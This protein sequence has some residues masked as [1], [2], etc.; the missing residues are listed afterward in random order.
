MRAHLFALACAAT[1]CLEHPILADDPPS[2][3][4]Q[5]EPVGPPAAGRVAIVLA[6][7]LG[8]GPDDFSKEVVAA[9][10]ADGHSV[11]ATTVPSVD[12]VA[13]RAAALGPQI[14]KM[15]AEAGVT[16]VHVIAHSMGGL[17]A[18][19][20]IATL[21][22]A[23]RIA[24]LT[25]ISTPH[26]GTALADAA[27]GLSGAAAQNDA[28]Q[29]FAELSPAADPAA[30]DRALRDLQT[31]AAP[32][33]NAANPDAAGVVYLSFAGFSTPE[34]IANANAP[35]ACGA[36]AIP[37]DRMR[38]ALLLAAPIVAE[39]LARIPNDGVVSVA[40]ATWTGFQGCIAADHLDETGRPAAIVPSLDAP[41]FYR[42]L[43]LTLA[44]L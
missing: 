40:S 30:L 4:Q 2:P 1:G 39:G 23:D 13:K 27:L 36:P 18:R 16:R 25:T 19:L 26:R 8:G 3:A 34:A 15:I 24:S 31:A 43:G 44:A 42:S 33:F 20:L 9:L 28:L 38:A 17:D 37:P 5:D 29:V 10:K 35:A 7:G 6:H 21:G 11:R 41:A 22:Y 12:G 32:A 14:D